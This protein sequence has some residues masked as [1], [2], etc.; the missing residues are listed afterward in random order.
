[1]EGSQSLISR[2]RN[3]GKVHTAE[4]ND[5][6]PS[7]WATL[8]ALSH[9]A[10]LVLLGILPFALFAYFS[11]GEDAPEEQETPDV[12]DEEA[13]NATSVQLAFPFAGPPPAPLAPTPPVDNVPLEIPETTVPASAKQCSN[14]KD[15]D[16]D[17]KKD[18]PSDRGCSSRSDSSESPNPPLPKPAPPKAPA[19][20][21][22]AGLPAPPAPAPKP[23]PAPPA[24]KTAC[25]NGLDDDGDGLRDGADPGCSGSLDLNEADPPPPPSP[26]PSPTPSVSPS[27][28]SSPSPDP[29][30]STGPGDPNNPTP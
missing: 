23:A 26:R 1:M 7:R 2:V 11:I 6:P 3:R 20:A 28:P 8:R 10:G 30:P 22:V 24:G 17:G 4:V 14:G 12:V 13:L 25:T 16:R 19:P 5:A 27:S 9:T 15:D 21:P 18:Y 29:D